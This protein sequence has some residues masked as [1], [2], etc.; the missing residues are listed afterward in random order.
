MTTEIKELNLDLGNLELKAVGFDS[1]D[2]VILKTLHNKIL[3]GSEDTLSPDARYLNYNDRRIWVGEGTLNNNIAKYSR[4][5]LVEQMLVMSCEVYNDDYLILD[6]KLG[7]PPS[8][9]KEDTHR[10][11]L[12]S[13]FELNKEYKFKI[14]KNNKWIDKTIKINNID[15]K[16]EG[17]SAFISIADDINNNGRDLLICDVG[18]NTTDAIKFSWSNKYQKFIPSTPFTISKGQVAMITDIQQKINSIHGADISF[19]KVDECILYNVEKILYGGYS[20]EIND[21]INAAS[22][23]ADLIINQLTDKFGSLDNYELILLGGG[24]K[25]FNKLK[26]DKIKHQTNICDADRFYAN[27][28]GYSMQ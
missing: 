1:N 18:G 22:D 27:A 17:Y 8:Q 14:R 20:Y 16:I 12:I 7:L 4:E 13:K 21:Y 15:V 2:N 9:Y 28:L 6:L 3:Q 11:E 25:L 26:S 23:S 19:D 10:N 5:F 24:H